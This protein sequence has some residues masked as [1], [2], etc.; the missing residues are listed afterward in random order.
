MAFYLYI[1]GVLTVG[2]LLAWNIRYQQRMRTETSNDGSTNAIRYC[3]FGGKPYKLVNFPPD[4]YVKEATRSIATFELMT[5]RDRDL[6]IDHFALDGTLKGIGLGETVLRGFARLVAE[7]APQ[8]DRIR[9][10][11]YRHTEESD[12]HKLSVARFKLLQKI[13]AH[14]VRTYQ[15][16]EHCICVSGTWERLIGAARAQAH[17]FKT[18]VYG[19]SSLQVLCVIV[20]PEGACHRTQ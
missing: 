5:L 1:L 18:L 12:I 7:Q 9:F 16:N 11:L 2:G 17:R 20:P 14:D 13:G 10:D 4:C 19:A 8:I 6:H 15:P 3:S